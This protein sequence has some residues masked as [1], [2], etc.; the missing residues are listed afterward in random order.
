VT[1]GLQEKTVRVVKG[2]EQSMITVKKDGAKRR[3]T[4]RSR[5]SRWLEGTMDTKRRPRGAKKIVF[6]DG[7]DEGR[8]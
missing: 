4:L 6:E 3:I 5:L 1:P 2:N 7:G 8:A